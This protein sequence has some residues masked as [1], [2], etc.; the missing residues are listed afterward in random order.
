MR[1]SNSS[2]I[3]VGALAIVVLSAAGFALRIEQSSKLPE[4]A[5]T[6]TV[7]TAVLGAT[8]H[9]DTSYKLS[10]KV[11][12][13]KLSQDGT[14]EHLRIEATMTNNSSQDLPMSPGLQTW[15]I[16]AEGER[17]E[18]TAEFVDSNTVVGGIIKVNKSMTVQLDY[19]I[20]P[21]SAPAML[22][23]QPD[24]A[25]QPLEATL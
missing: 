2:S 14:F 23:F 12:D 10:A 13:K 4:L 9:T 11:I 7:K 19:K 25:T 5:T 17:V 21:N 24:A 1:I 3:L 16:T 15:L 6:P 8:E 18:Y 20:T 22:Y